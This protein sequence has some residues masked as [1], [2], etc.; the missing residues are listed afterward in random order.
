[1]T[2]GCGSPTWTVGLTRPSKS[3]ARKAISCRR[4]SSGGSSNEKAVPRLP[5]SSGAPLNMAD[6]DSTLAYIDQGSF[7]GLR[8]LGR[9]PL[10][11][12]AWIYERQVD[13]DGLRRFHHNLGRGLLGRRIERSPLP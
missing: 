6:V 1:M 7:L 10:A 3:D 2:A 9:G 12:Y 11:Q 5:R 13:L 8:A 4:T